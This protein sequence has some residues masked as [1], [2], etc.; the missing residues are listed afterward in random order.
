MGSSR[1]AGKLFRDLVSNLH[2][3]LKREADLCRVGE[4]GNLRLLKF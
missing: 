1:V 2:S 3:N 4:S